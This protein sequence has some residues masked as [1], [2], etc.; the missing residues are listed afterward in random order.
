MKE[1]VAKEYQLWFFLF[2]AT[3]ADIT[4]LAIV[5]LLSLDIFIL[6]IVLI[7]ILA[8]DIPIFVYYSRKNRAI[9]YMNQKAEELMGA[10]A[11]EKNRIVF[12]RPLDTE[13]GIFTMTYSSSGEYAYV[14][15][16][17]E[18]KGQREVLKEIEIPRNLEFFVGFIYKRLA[19]IKI[20]AFRILNGEYHIDDKNCIIIGLVPPM[21]FKQKAG[22]LTI[23]YKQDLAICEWALDGQ[24]LYCTLTY[25]PDAIS[26][27]T[28]KAKIELIARYNRNQT[29]KK[30]IAETSSGYIKEKFKKRLLP[31]ITE[32]IVFVISRGS[33][34]ALFWSYRDSQKIIEK[35]GLGD[36]EKKDIFGA[37]NIT[38]RLTLDVPFR[39]DIYSEIRLE[40]EIVQQ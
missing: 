12:P 22:R 5:V 25:Q 18:P 19:I 35:M 8:I 26:H 6:F 14:R 11:V 27:A 7:A 28:R 40:P 30:V 31:D 29:I 10:I 13:Y 3:T 1:L 20:P 39:K 4:I 16:E 9:G 34:G 36:L 32:P 2:I 37:N 15:T 21:R 33:I 23:E 24:Y 17:F 38:L